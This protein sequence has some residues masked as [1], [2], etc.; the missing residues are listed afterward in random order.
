MPCTSR[1]TIRTLE[2]L[3]ERAEH[4]AR[5][6]HAEAAERDPP[7]AEAVDERA[8]RKEHHAV[9]D[10]VGRQHE[11]QAV[12]VDVELVADRRQRDGDDRPVYLEQRRGGR[13]RGEPQPRVTGDRGRLAASG[14]RA[15]HAAHSDA[16]ERHCVG[17]AATRG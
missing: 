11:R 5:G 2:A 10:E 3:R 9:G 8:A 13:A 7:R 17:A 16:A 4:R 1:E 14:G 12:R 15:G 6:E